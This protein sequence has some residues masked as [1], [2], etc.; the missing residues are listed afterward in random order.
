LEKKL[1]D[2]LEMSGTETAFKL[3][4]LLFSA[5][6]QMIANAYA[7]QYGFNSFVSASFGIESMSLVNAFGVMA[8][9]YLLNYGPV[10]SQMR[11]SK[12]YEKSTTSTERFN[13]IFYSHLGLTLR[14][15]VAILFMYICNLYM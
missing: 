7:I 3:T 4:I 11:I 1:N 9:F 14:P 5:P 10:Y 8:M 15:L 13:D 12:L 6:L 2:R